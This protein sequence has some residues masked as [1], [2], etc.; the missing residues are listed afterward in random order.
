MISKPLGI[1]FIHSNINSR[2]CNKF[3]CVRRHEVQWYPTIR[4]SGFY[5]EKNIIYKLIACFDEL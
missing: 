1:E 5:T 3:M 4:F 2:S